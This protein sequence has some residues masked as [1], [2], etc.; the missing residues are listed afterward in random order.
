[1]AVSDFSKKCNSLNEIREEVE[2][3]I[4][5][6]DFSIEKIEHYYSTYSETN[7][8][9]GREFNPNYYKLMYPS[10]A[11]SKHIEYIGS[12]ILAFKSK[13]CI[14]NVVYRFSNLKKQSNKDVMLYIRRS[15]SSV[16]NYTDY[17]DDYGQYLDASHDN[18][19]L[20]DEIEDARNVILDRAECFG[21]KAYLILGKHKTLCTI[22]PKKD[23]DEMKSAHS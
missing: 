18:D 4:R 2:K 3:V 13:S 23:I 6:I 1:M 12:C 16:D 11:L 20:F 14:D 22:V 8:L 7:P 9:K 5:L 15:N 10:D 19:A 17:I 21:K